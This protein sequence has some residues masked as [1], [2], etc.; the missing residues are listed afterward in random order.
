MAPATRSL[1]A[2]TLFLLAWTGLVAGDRIYVHPFHFLFY[3]KSSCDQLKSS[4]ET[5]AEPTFTPAPIQA[6]TP[7]LNEAHLRDQL[8][9]AAGK[10]EAEEKLR[11]A[12]VGMMANFMGFRMY[13]MLSE[14]GGTSH[15]AVLSPTALFGTLASFYLGSTDPTASQLQAFLGVPGKDQDCTSRLDGHK[16]LSALQAIQGLLV[17]QGEAG[18]QA[19]L[20]L[21]TVV[22]LFMA[23]GLQLKQPFVKG[24]APF[25]PVVLPRSLDLSSPH[26][27]AEKIRQFMQAVTGWK[28]NGLPAGVSADSTMLFNTYVHFQGRLKGFSLLAEPQ[29]FRVDNSTRVSVHMLSGSGTFQHWHDPQNNLSMT[30]VPL[31]E[32][33]SLLLLKPGC[34]S[35]L[36]RVQALAF[37]QDLFIW[38]KNASPRTLHLTLPQLE[39][40]GAYDLQAL[41]AQA[42][43]PTLLGAQAALGRISDSGV[44]VGEVLNSVLF[45]LKADEGEQPTESA[46]Q[47]EMTEALEV[48]LNS[49]FLFAIH[50]RDSGALHFLGRVDNP[51]A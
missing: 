15:G 2:I 26:V 27:A 28:M 10:L 49:P 8:L 4:A 47:S 29:E 3:S 51:R 13:K 17:A 50:E 42:K 41:L 11:A 33:A 6:K 21:S 36:D 45:E 1:K 30:S 14:V 39:L 23:P 18:G 38:M 20:L 43:L 12:E 9:M 19:R 48:T 32:N 5:A 40:R 44:R 24:L 46:P 16:V 35:E 22:G 31:G 25:A 7:P 34:A 37:H